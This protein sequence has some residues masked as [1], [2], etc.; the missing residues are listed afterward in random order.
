MFAQPE[1]KS[2]RRSDAPQWRRDYDCCPFTCPSNRCRK[3]RGARQRRYLFFPR[4]LPEEAG[5]WTGY[6][7]DE[8]QGQEKGE[9]ERKF[10]DSRRGKWARTILKVPR[11][12]VLA[13][14][15]GKRVR[16]PIVIIVLHFLR[17]FSEDFE[18]LPNRS[19][20]LMIKLPPSYTLYDLDE[21]K[22]IIQKICN[23]I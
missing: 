9:N 6:T 22:N 13:L 20:I 1:R 2:C 12:R 16:P 10:E 5:P 21:N 14:M 11:T 8:K 19:S 3:P 17:E 15:Q 7:S 18:Q 4:P 23:N